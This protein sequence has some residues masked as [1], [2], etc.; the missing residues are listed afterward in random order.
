MLHTQ[1]VSMAIYDIYDRV[2]YRMGIEG[3][4]TSPCTNWFSFGTVYFVGLR[5]KSCIRTLLIRNKLET[6]ALD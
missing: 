6:Y 4:P 2:R 3:I 1:I 5:R